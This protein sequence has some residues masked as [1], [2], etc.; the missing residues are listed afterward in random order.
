MEHASTLQIFLVVVNMWL[1][2]WSICLRVGRLEERVGRLETLVRQL[3]KD[4]H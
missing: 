1:L 2:Y 3:W 4:A